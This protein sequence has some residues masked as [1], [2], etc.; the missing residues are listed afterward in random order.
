MIGASVALSPKT[1]A[2][3]PPREPCPASKAATVRG[4]QLARRRWR[5]RFVGGVARSGGAISRELI[6]CDRSRTGDGSGGKLE[7]KPPAALA[8]AAREHGGRFS[9]V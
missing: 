8:L 2:T 7:V 1:S 9:H 4:R 3:A 6:S 5:R